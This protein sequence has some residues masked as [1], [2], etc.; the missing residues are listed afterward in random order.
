MAQTKKKRSTK[1][2]GNAAGGVE[3]RGRTGRKLTEA[4]KGK[5][6]KARGARAERGDRF[7]KPPTWTGAIQRSLIAIVIFIAVIVLVFKQNPLAAV[8]LA[9]VLLVVY[10]P[11]SYYTDQILYRRRQAKKL[12]G[13]GGGNKRKKDAT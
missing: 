13:G 11:L 3:A 7:D 1:H 10:I 8:G 9:S 12:E 6:A 5:N 2:R 4:E